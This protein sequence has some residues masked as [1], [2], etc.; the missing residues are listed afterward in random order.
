MIGA[1]Y[2]EQASRSMPI[3]LSL[4]MPFGLFALEDL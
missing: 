2:T 1:I 4:G 3:K